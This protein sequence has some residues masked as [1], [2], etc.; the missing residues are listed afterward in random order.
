[1]ELDEKQQEFVREKMLEFI[2]GY[3]DA[4][5]T[6]PQDYGYW[7]SEN[8]LYVEKEYDRILFNEKK[9]LSSNYRRNFLRKILGRDN[10]GIFTHNFNPEVI[11]DLYLFYTGRKDELKYDESLDTNNWFIDTYGGPYTSQYKIKEEIMKFIRC[12]NTEDVYMEEIFNI[13]NWNNTT[14]FVIGDNLSSNIQIFCIP[15]E[16]TDKMEFKYMYFPGDNTHTQRFFKLYPAFNVM[17]ERDIEYKIKESYK[18]YRE[19]HPEFAQ[20]AHVF[21]LE[22]F[23]HNGQ[24]YYHPFYFMDLHPLNCSLLIRSILKYILFGSE[25]F[26][27]FKTLS[28][29]RKEADNRKKSERKRITKEKQHLQEELRKKRRQSL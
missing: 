23:T 28:T 9:E 8:Y 19:F 27:E 18:M 12:Q 1:M 24:S 29:R 7:D 13:E 15:T 16:Q 3:H 2:Y 5:G 20:F 26:R 14:Y 4:Y 21:Y 11:D 17:D 25:D 22:K 6:N 10:V